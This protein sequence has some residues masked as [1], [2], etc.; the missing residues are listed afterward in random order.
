MGVTAEGRLAPFWGQM[1]DC[2]LEE[3]DNEDEDLNLR[4]EGSKDKNME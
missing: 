4:P 3:K 2:T 1:S